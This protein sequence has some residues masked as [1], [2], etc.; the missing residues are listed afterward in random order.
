MQGRRGLEPA[1]GR[2]GLEHERVEMY[3]A[4][5]FGQFVAQTGEGGTHEGK[6]ASD[7]Q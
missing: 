3:H 6:Q 1:L 4:S 7:W 2:R 5:A